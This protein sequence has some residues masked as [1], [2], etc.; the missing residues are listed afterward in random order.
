MMDFVSGLPLSL[1]KKYAIWVIVDRLAKVAHF[2]PVRINYS[3]EKLAELNITK[4]VRLYEEPLSI[5]SDR[6]PRFTSQFW[7]KLQ[8]ALGTKLHFSNTFHLQTVGQS[9]RIIQVLEDMLRCCILEFEST[10]ENHLPLIEFAY[11]NSFQSSIKMAPYEALY[12][13]NCQT[14]LYWTELC[15]NKIHGIDLIKETEQKVNVIRNSLKVASDRQKSYADLKRK[16]IEFEVDDKIV[17]VEENTSIW[18]KRQIESEVHRTVIAPAEVEIQSDLSYSEEPIRILAR[19]IKELRNKRIP[20][21]KVLRHKHG[22][23]EAT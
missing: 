9:E 1:R 11:N 3:L 13:R 22:I 12:G 4:I 17:P 23:E 21:V 5:V 20:L 16:D 6:D 2:V 15:E 10:W 7:K 19:E 18:L 8:E 14:P